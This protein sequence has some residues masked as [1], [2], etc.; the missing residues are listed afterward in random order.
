VKQCLKVY[1]DKSLAETL[2]QEATQRHLPLSQHLA[3]CL[4]ARP[5]MCAADEVRRRTMFQR[6]VGV[7]SDSTVEQV[8]KAL[9]VAYGLPVWKP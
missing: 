7:I 5:A 2:Q 3:Q 4:M 1:V 8:L 9:A 6:Y